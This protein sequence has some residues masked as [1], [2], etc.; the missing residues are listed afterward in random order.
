MRNILASALVVATAIG[1]GSVAFADTM[2]TTPQ[3]GMTVQQSVSGE[4]QTEGTILIM[5]GNNREVVLNDGKVYELPGAFNL[6]A[7]N[8]GEHVQIDWKLYGTARIAS[9]MTHMS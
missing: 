9:N 6:K 5:H 4:M 7:F 2:A 3:V 8:V 1:L